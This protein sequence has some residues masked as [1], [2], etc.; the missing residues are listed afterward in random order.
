M[1]T[2]IDHPRLRRWLV[3]STLLALASSTMFATRHSANAAGCDATAS[4]AT[5]QARIDAAAPGTTLCLEPGIYRGTLLVYGKG[6]VTIAGA[7]KFRTIISGGAVDALDV[8]NSDGVT[9]RDLTLYAGSPANVY[10]GRSTNVVLSGLDVGAGG[11][12]VHIDDGSSATLSTS[13]VYA[14]TNDGVLLRRGS[15]ALIER[16][17]IFNNQGVGV[18][19]VGNTGATALVR[20]I[21]SDNR[22]PGVFAGA[23]GCANLPGASLAVPSCYL[24][25]PAAYV[26]SADLTFDTNIVQASGSTGI[27]LFPGARATMYGNRIWR[28]T[29]TGLFVWG[30]DLTSTRDEYDGN[31]EHAIE[32]RGYPD[33]RIASPG[34]R[35]ATARF[36]ATVIRNTLVWPGSGTLGGGLI[37]HG[38]SVD[39][40]N[41]QVYGN[42]GIGI[43]YQTGSTGR[44]EGN[45]VHDNGGAAICLYGA[46]AVYIGANQTYGNATNVP[47]AC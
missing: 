5:A 10:V 38:A 14:M 20:N 15:S 23:T 8:I 44:V 39:V 35:R 40:T 26:G 21:I 33:P 45:A 47:G 2:Q 42:A 37:A 7:G 22:G 6:G 31:D 43:T 4:P 27:V 46:G 36:D 25:N 24:A 1:E 41:A 3:A 28:N 18:S 34:Y 19:V 32:I 9:V 12:G 16:N 11:I 13:F 30:A 29:L 17:W